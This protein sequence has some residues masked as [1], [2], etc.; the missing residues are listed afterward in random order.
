[1]HNIY[2][3]IYM[4]IPCRRGVRSH[5]Y[6]MRSLPGWLGPRLAQNRFNYLKLA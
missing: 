1:M 6:Y 3:Y 2:I 5:L 4:F